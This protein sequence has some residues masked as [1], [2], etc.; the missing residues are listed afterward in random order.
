M[1]VFSVLIVGAV[2]IMV[3]QLWS[4]RQTT[5]TETLP[6]NAPPKMLKPVFFTASR[7]G[8]G[9]RIDNKSAVGWVG[10]VAQSG[11]SKAIISEIG[12]YAA[13]VLRADQFEPGF[14]EQIGRGLDIACEATKSPSAA[15][16]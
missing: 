5:S 2:V 11:A 4:T 3:I 9:W 13:I 15:E 10:C 14:N 8:D 16:R 1:A 12:P 6:E 7:E